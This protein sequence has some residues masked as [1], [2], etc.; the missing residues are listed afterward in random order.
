MET[1]GYI[2][3]NPNPSTN[4]H[5]DLVRDRQAII[6]SSLSNLFQCHE[7]DRGRIFR[8]DYYTRL[9]QLL[10]EPIDRTTSNIIRISLIQS[11]QKWEPRIELIESDTGV[12]P[13]YRIPGYHVVVS[14]R[15]RGAAEIHNAEFE[16]KYGG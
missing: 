8:P 2:D 9:Y 12:V 14:F 7:G 10:Q 16:V 6:I 15:F 11:I 5:G 13:D 3:V 1:L 4:T